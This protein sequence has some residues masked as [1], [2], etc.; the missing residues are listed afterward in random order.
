MKR[1]VK[2]ALAR[3]TTPQKRRTGGGT[4]SRYLA[5][6]TQGDQM[7]GPGCCAHTVRVK[8]HFEGGM[9]ELLYQVQPPRSRELRR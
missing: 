6:V 3:A 7:Y 5:K 2:Q 8:R 1:K 9:D 4:M